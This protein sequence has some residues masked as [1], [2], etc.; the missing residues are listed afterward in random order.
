[1]QGGKAADALIQRLTELVGSRQSD[2]ELASPEI[3]PLFL[4]LGNCVADEAPARPATVRAALRE[5][6][7][8][9]SLDSL[10]FARLLALGRY[11]SALH[12][13]AS[14]AFLSGA[15]LRSAGRA[16]GTALYWQ[17]IGDEK[18]GRLGQALTSFK[19]LICS[20]DRALR[21]A[22]ALG[23][24]VLCPQLQDEGRKEERVSCT[25][26][27]RQAGRGLVPMLFS[28]DVSEQ[29][30]AAWG[31][32]ELASFRVWAP[33]VE[34]DALG[35]LFSLWQHSPNGE[36]RRLA[37]WALGRQQICTRDSGRRCAIVTR[38]DL[39]QLLATYDAL[40]RKREQPAVLASAWYSRGVS[41]EEL[42][43]RARALLAVVDDR[44]AEIT[45][46]ELLRQLGERL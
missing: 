32:F 3:E 17:T 14:E 6:I 5:L 38:A 28:E 25:D 4:A 15:D 23:M 29:W 22:G 34:P 18:P 21:C 8:S 27:L 20:E 10:P 46:R 30:G 13:Q 43:A 24:A 33:P 1:V 7:R 9:G 42:A 26:T 2:R 41:D 16:F 40:S 45:V 44:L 36:M 39:D 11:G 19:D 12:D 31:L 35:R 37:G